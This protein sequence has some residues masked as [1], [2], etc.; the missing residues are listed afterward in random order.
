MLMCWYF[1][2]LKQ[3]SAAVIVDGISVCSGPFRDHLGWL[4]VSLTQQVIPGV[5]VKGSDCP[6]VDSESSE[7]CLLVTCPSALWRKQTEKLPGSSWRGGKWSRDRRWA[8]CVCVCGPAGCCVDIDRQCFLWCFGRND[9]QVR[10]GERRWS[11][12]T[13]R[14]PGLIQMGTPPG[15]FLSCWNTS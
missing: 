9:K 4:C 7:L 8:V 15:G 1:V 3:S 10:T 11:L 14:Q 13:A 12:L 6:S 5:S 2:A